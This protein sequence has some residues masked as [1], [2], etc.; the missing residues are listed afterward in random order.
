MKDKNYIII[1]YAEETFD[2][3]QILFMIKTSTTGYR[4]D[5]AEHNKCCSKKYSFQNIT[6]HC[7][8]TWLP[9]SSDGDVQ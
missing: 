7:Q 3:I 5:V 4:C 8:C 6:A 1:S 9:K 2:E